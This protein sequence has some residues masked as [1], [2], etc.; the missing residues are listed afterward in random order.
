MILNNLIWSRLIISTVLSLVLFCCRV[1]AQPN[2]PHPQPV[3]PPVTQ[4]D[5]LSWIPVHFAKNNM[6]V[7]SAIARNLFAVKTGQMTPREFYRALAELPM[8]PGKE[9]RHILME[10]KKDIAQYRGRDG[11]RQ[12]LGTQFPEGGSAVEMTLLSWRR[13]LVRQGINQTI[14]ALQ[15]K[16]RINGQAFSIYYAEVGSWPQ[17]SLRQMQF[18]G[19]IDF[20]FISGNIDLALQ[21]KQH[22]DAFIQ[23]EIGMTPEMLDAPCT[24]HGLATPE[25]FVGKHGQAFAEGA[26]SQVKRIDTGGD[27]QAIPF[28]PFREALADM[29]IEGRLAAN[30]LP[31]LQKTN[32][33]TEP[34]ITLEMIRHF[35]HDV[36]GKNVFTDLQSFMKAAKYMERS[37]QA[38]RNAGGTVSHPALADF[39]ERLI[40]GKRQSSQTQA[41]IL[42]AYFAERGQPIPLDITLGPTAAGNTRLEIEFKERLIRNFWDD[43]QKAMWDNA[44]QGLDAQLRRLKTRKGAA[45]DS[46]EFAREL[47]QMREMVEVEMR[48]LADGDVGIKNIPA[49]F[50]KVV[51]DFR[52]FC[53]GYFRSKGY[54]NLRPIE[55]RQAYQFIED[56]LRQGRPTNVQLALGALIHAPDKINGYLD[57]LDDTLLGE[58]RGEK[59]DWTS[60]LVEARELAWAKK[61]D[62]FLG[63]STLSQRQRSFLDEVEQKNR[64]IETKLTKLLS[65]SAAA[66]GVRSVNQLFTRSFESSAAG[67]TSLKAMTAIN[68]AQEI[69]VYIDLFAKEDWSGLAAEFIIRRVPFGSAANNLYMGRYLLAVW[70]IGVTIVPPAALA[71]LSFRMGEWA[72]DQAWGLY[73]AE[74]LEEFIDDLYDDAAFQLI[75][76]EEIDG[77]I[78]LSQWRLVIVSYGGKEFADIPGFI[79]MKRQQIDEMH[80]QCALPL[81]RREFPMRYTLDGI[82]DWMKLSGILR[83]NIVAQDPFLVLVEEMKNAPHVGPKLKDHYLDLWYTRYEEVKL[84]YVLHMIQ[85]LEE[86]RS[87][88]QAYLSGQ[89]PLMAKQLQQ[90]AASLQIQDLVEQ[91]LE[92]EMGGSLYALYAWARDWALGIKRGLSGEADVWSHDKEC[93]RILQRYL[94]TY[95]DI[96]QIRARL[97]RATSTQSKGDL[98]LRILTGPLML[99]GDP[100]KDG[101]AAAR[102]GQAFEKI[103]A[104]VLAELTAIKDRHAKAQKG[105]STDPE[106]YDQRVYRSIVAHD[107]WGEVWK[108]VFRSAPKQSFSVFDESVLMK[109]AR[110]LK[111]AAVGTQDNMEDLAK[112]NHIYH[113]KQRDAI[114]AAFAAYYA[115]LAEDDGARRGQADDPPAFVRKST[116]EKRPIDENNKKDGPPAFVTRST[117]PGPGPDSDPPAFVKKSVPPRAANPP[118]GVRS[119]GDDEIQSIALETIAVTRHNKIYEKVNDLDALVVMVRRQGQDRIVDGAPAFAML[120][121]QGYIYSVPGIGYVTSE[122]FDD[123]MGSAGGLGRADQAGGPEEGRPRYAVKECATVR[124]CLPSFFDSTMR[125]YHE[126]E[127]RFGLDHPFTRAE[128]RARGISSGDYEFDDFLHCKTVKQDYAILQSYEWVRRREGGIP[129]N[130]TCQPNNE[131]FFI[132]DQGRVPYK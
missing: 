4:D 10:V 19:D 11:L 64:L 20:N 81:G 43:C 120:K 95:Q 99:S 28:M 93:V 110:S 66:R 17:E 1:S 112:D 32:W 27:I 48:V 73:W 53:K 35:E 61:V 77:K 116:G 29:H 124:A 113:K 85:R 97:E 121:E 100:G 68:L 90:T 36:R 105:L 130:L 67:R 109:I 96:E 129:D 83:E 84:A 103:Q 101:A 16:N 3:S 47:D 46:P 12:I 94:K 131:C 55:E 14:Q 26:I 76:T 125:E 87:A 69:P 18:A 88:E 54:L 57:I 102:W 40:A 6:D 119:R 8:P 62:A 21:M 34:G 75:G 37:D 70:D 117:K 50:M 5:D 98:G 118:V 104:A 31:D 89:L 82:T 38:I 15:G 44:A 9:P 24:V 78:R 33:P 58:I 7:K 49:P 132:T 2:S 123:F 71:E 86:R 91:D 108:A 80:A 107:F 106:S 127:A 41:D 52:S 63:R 23:R 51:A 72:A 111:S 30:P 115:Q 74:E 128:A 42:R 13:D 39:C 65:D 22:F 45:G 122:K 92:D 25:V 114:L 56:N 59:G 126:C 79:R 60:W